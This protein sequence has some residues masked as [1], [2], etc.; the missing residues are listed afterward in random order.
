MLLCRT[1]Y[2]SEEPNIFNYV[3]GHFSLT[4]SFQHGLFYESVTM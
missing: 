2:R 1:A 4:F 3:P